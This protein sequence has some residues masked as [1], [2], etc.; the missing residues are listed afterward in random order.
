M[1]RDGNWINTNDELPNSDMRC[2]VVISSLAS[3]FE[4]SEQIVISQYWK[5]KFDI[6]TGFPTAWLPVVT[7]WMF[8]PMLP[9]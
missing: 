6:P 9:D 1:V 3:T 7:H 2:L 4:E 8:L 5:G